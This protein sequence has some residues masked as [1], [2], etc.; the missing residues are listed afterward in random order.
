MPN[1]VRV[2][3]LME[4]STVT[5]PAKNLIR[6]CSSSVGRADMTIATFL[7]AAHNGSTSNPFI[8]AVRKA[9]LPVEVIPEQS[10]FDH[11]V[12]GK[13]AEMVDRIRPSIVQTHGVK[14][15]FLMW[16]SGLPRRY[17]WIAYH[18]GY[19]AED[20]KMKLYNQLNYISLPRADRVLTVCQPFAGML[21]KTGISAARISVLHNTIEPFQAPAAEQIHQARQRLGLEDNERLLLTVGRLSAEKGHA[22]LIAALAQRKDDPALPPFRLAIIG[23]GIE[24]ER[25][26]HL[27]SAAGLASRIVFTGHCSDVRPYYSLASLFV[28]PSHSEGSP[29]VLLEAMAAGLPIVVTAVG[30]VPEI[31]QHEA[32]ALLVPPRNPGALAEAISRLLGEEDFAAQL[33]RRASEEVSLRF[34]PGVY[35]ESLLRIYEEIAQSGGK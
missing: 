16:A 15:H 18:H 29:N 11:S 32:T 34:T 25:L 23:D 7:R 8:D 33:A 3:A 9:G 5:G 20:W 4:A 28:L 2:V 10:R 12:L 13:L 31:V 24:R 35:R 27:A 14:G 21:V 26:T 17:R 30:G 19:T 6:F 1:A 22:D